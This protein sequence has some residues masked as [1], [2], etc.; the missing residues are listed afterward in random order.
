[1]LLE[2]LLGFKRYFRLNVLRC[3]GLMNSDAE[4]SLAH[5]QNCHEVAFSQ[6]DRLHLELTTKS[7]TCHETKVDIGWRGALV[8]KALERSQLARPSP[9]IRVKGPEFLPKVHKP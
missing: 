6:S 7:S 2:T 5:L 1:M 4:C 9:R 8:P 3:K